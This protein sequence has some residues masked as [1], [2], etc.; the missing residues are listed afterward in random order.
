M[1]RLLEIAIKNSIQSNE[2][3]SEFNP[4]IALK[5]N[6]FDLIGVSNIE[7]VPIQ[8]DESS[9]EKIVDY[10]T[11]FLTKRFVFKT[12]KH[13]IYFLSEIIGQSKLINH[14]PKIIIEGLSAIIETYT[15]D[16]NDI[17]ELDL[18]LTGFIDEVYSD[19][20]FI[21]RA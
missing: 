9:W 12:E 3:N 5:R 1:S 8:A 10:N 6:N 20:V 18:E 2:N 13:L 17:T 21:H 11:N 14:H 16:L 15:H 7:E 4:D 19:I